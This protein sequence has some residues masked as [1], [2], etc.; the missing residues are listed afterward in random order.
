MC[1][2]DS[3]SAAISRMPDA[4]ASLAAWP[5][6]NGLLFLLRS[7][8]MAYNEVVIAQMDRAGAAKSLRRFA[9]LLLVTTTAITLAIVTT[10]LAN[11]WLHTVMALSP[12]LTRISQQALWLG[13]GLP[14]LA[15]L[16]SWYQ[17]G[18]MHSKHTRGITEATTAYSLIMVAIFGAGIALQRYEG[19]FVA[20]VAYEV[21]GLAQV[22]WLWG[23]SQRTDEFAFPEITM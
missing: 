22:G 19:L 5:V 15:V 17:G 20:I 4:L 12:D 10:P 13:L 21:A 6:V 16:I 11:I 1:I 7:P 2:R 9:T 18:L 8:G 3:G 14:A 23:R